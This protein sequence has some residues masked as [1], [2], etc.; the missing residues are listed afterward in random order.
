MN[1][2]DIWTAQYF[3][4]YRSDKSLIS[5]AKKIPCFRYFITD[6]CKLLLQLFN[7]SFT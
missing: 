7:F 3:C 5:S 4:R 2:P 6:L 1:K